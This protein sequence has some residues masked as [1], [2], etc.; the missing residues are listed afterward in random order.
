MAD[1]TLTIRLEPIQGQSGQYLLSWNDIH[2]P[3][4]LRPENSHAFSELLLHL[5]TVLMGLGDPAGKLTPPAFLSS[6]GERL[7][8][9][10]L[11][12]TASP[13]MRNALAQPLRPG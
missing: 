7:W 9:A 13:E 5:P 4:V 11:P 12:E 10:L 2:Y 8:S 6:I 3:I 1:Q